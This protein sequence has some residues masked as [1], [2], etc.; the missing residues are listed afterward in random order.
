MEEEYQESSSRLFKTQPL[1]VVALP[2][3]PVVEQ[4]LI[5]QRQLIERFPVYTREPFPPLHVTLATLNFPGAMLPEIIKRMETVSHKIDPIPVKSSGFGCFGHPS[6]AVTV[7]IERSDELDTLTRTVRH[8]LAS[9][10]LLQPLSV[11]R[12]AYH[13]TLSSAI[14]ADQPWDEGTFARAC[15]YKSVEFIP[16]SGTLTTLALWFPE[17]RPL[18]EVKRFSLSKAAD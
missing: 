17:F 1:Y 16:L 6:L 5:W 8:A 18:A 2:D 11:E 4:A 3:G 7:Y 14:T 13:M 15:Y 9:T 12:W 10:D